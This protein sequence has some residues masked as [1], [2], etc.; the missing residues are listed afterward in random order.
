MITHA[1]TVKLPDVLYERI[2]RRATGAKH[3]IEDEL[4]A[5]VSEA[6]SD[7]ST[8]LPATLAERLGQLQVLGDEDLWR[9]AELRVPT[10][11]AERLEV[12]AD[13]Q[14]AEGLSRAE[15]QELDRLV[16]MG[17]QVMLVRAEAA[18]LLKRRGY[19]ISRLLQQSPSE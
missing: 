14:E 18:V 5:V 13:K 6:L 9:A 10:E 3:S 11:K 7:A 19:D 15:R 1:I 16:N 12:L 2:V 17:H 4:A 8:V